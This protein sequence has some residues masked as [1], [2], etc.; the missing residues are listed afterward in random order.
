M[1]KK[2]CCIISALAFIV[3]AVC[4]VVIFKKKR[5]YYC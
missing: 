2:R 5:G 4:G 1:N 3:A